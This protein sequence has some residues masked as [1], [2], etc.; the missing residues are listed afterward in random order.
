MNDRTPLP[1]GEQSNREY[2]SGDPQP[3]EAENCRG[4]QVQYPEW[5]GRTETCPECEGTGHNG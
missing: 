5:E 2:H 3:C 4:G 1:M